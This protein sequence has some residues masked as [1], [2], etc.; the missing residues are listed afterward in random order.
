MRY[1]NYAQLRA[2]SRYDGIYLAIIWIASFAALALMPYINWMSMVS[3][4]LAVSTPFFVGYKIKRFHKGVLKG[5][6]TFSMALI[7]ALRMFFIAAFF[8]AIA[9]WAYLTY[10]DGGRL[11]GYFTMVL[12][13]PENAEIMRKAGLSVTDYTRA[14]QAVSPLEMASSYFIQ[15]CL[16]GSM[17][18]IVIAFFIKSKPTANN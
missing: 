15:N 2:W 10:L 14:I 16:I 11:M 17:M 13:A 12:S 1:E 18:S 3:L 7:Y 8:F 5:S 9:Q 4:A 6:L